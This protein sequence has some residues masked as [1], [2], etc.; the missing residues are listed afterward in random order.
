MRAYNEGKSESQKINLY[1]MDAQNSDPSARVVQAAVRQYDNGYPATYNDLASALLVDLTNFSSIEAFTAAL[2]DQRNRLAQIRS[3]M[4]TNS[5]WYIS[6]AGQGGY[7]LL[8]QHIR[9]TEQR[10]AQAA[11]EIASPGE[12]FATRDRSMA[13]NVR[14]IEQYT[15]G[16]KIAVWVH[17]GHI[18]LQP[19]TY[20]SQT[21]INVLGTNLKTAYGDRFYSIDFIFNEGTFNAY[22]FKGN[23]PRDRDFTMQPY[24]NAVLARALATQSVQVFFYDMRQ[25]NQGRL[26]EVFTPKYETY[27]VGA[28]ASDDVKDVTIAYS[29]IKEFDGFIFVRKTTAFK[30]Y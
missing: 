26:V 17:N 4:E 18:A 7:N 1:G 24:E 9:I 8:L 27:F 22:D 16:G 11:A 29:P 10:L 2:P 13:D 30:L 20:V 28:G 12:G 19:Q 3:H 14:W 5:S 21:P 6:G 23:P 15:G 25:S